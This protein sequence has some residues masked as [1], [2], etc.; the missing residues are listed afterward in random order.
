MN[1]AD[2]LFIGIL[3]VSLM[4]GVMRGFV[5][6]GIALLVWLIGLWLAWHYAD[7]LHPYL[8]GT[9][10]QPGLRE[11]VARVLMLALVLL[12][13]SAIGALVSY[14]VTRATGLAVTDRLLGAMFGLFRA[15]VMIGVF[16]IVGQGLDL[17]GER[18]W[19]SS[20]LMPYAEHAGS[21]L[22]RYAEPAVEPLLDEA[23][24]LIRR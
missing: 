18:W 9:L 4:L 8:G 20:R 19:K 16:V 21:W 6:E 1:G 15:L 5:R 23:A 24:D 22:E 3:V 7:L 2:Y 13:G 11:W 14:L 17:D 12:V 10:A